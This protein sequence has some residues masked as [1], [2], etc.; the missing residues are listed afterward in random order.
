M[1]FATYIGKRSGNYRTGEK[2]ALRLHYPSLLSKLFKWGLSTDVVVI[3]E[4]NGNHSY[5]FGEFFSN[6]RIERDL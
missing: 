1:T 5:S 4:K 3:S 2:Y 6:W